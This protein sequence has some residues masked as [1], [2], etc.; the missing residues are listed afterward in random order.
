M[1]FQEMFGILM[2]RAL[3]WNWVHVALCFAELEDGILR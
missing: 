2:R 1:S 3:P